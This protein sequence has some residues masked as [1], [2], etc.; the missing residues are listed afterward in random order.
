LVAAI[1]SDDTSLKI[2]TSTGPEW[3]T[4]AEP[5]HILIDGEAMT[6]T[7]MSTDTPAFIAA[8]TVAHANNASVTPGLPA[9][10]TP[11]VGQLIIG[12]AAIRNSG[13]GSPN[14]PAG[15]SQIGASGNVLAFAKY[16]VTGDAAPTISFTGGVANADTSARLFGF[17][18]LSRNLDDGRYKATNPSPQAQLN[19]S[20]QNVAYPA[21][22]VRRD[23]GVVL[24]LFWKQDD[25]TGY[26]TVADAEILDNSTTTGDDQSIAADYDIY[27]TATDVAAGS[28]TVT[29][30]AS[31]ISRAIVLALRPLQTA[32]V[33]RSVNGVS[34][35]IA[36]DKAVHGWRMGV[37]AL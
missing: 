32:T 34:K 20:A 19:G 3:S 27:T 23:G 8:G 6:V 9:G 1:D 35:S 2:A 5:Y 17:S 24:Y 31:A 13:T 10:M 21:L 7:A 16:Y 26:A 33:T 30:G 29:G 11:D 22:S 28:V 12:W 15:Y 4:T 25:A 37:L 36:A 14:L 18:G